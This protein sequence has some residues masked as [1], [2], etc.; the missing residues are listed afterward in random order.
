MTQ[1]HWPLRDI[2]SAAEHNQLYEPSSEIIH[3]SL[4]QREQS[5]FPDDL[6]HWMG[7]LNESQWQTQHR[8]LHLLQPW[9]LT[10]KEAPSSS[11]S[12]ARQRNI[13]PGIA[14]PFKI[15]PL[16]KVGTRAGI[17]WNM[18]KI[19]WL[20]Y[21]ER[22][23][24][25][26][27]RYEFTNVY[28]NTSMKV[29]LREYGPFHYNNFGQ[30][31]KKNSKEK[32]NWSVLMFQWNTRHGSNGYRKLCRNEAVIPSREGRWAGLRNVLFTRLWTQ[33]K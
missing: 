24:Y 5:Y 15:I 26:Y 14:H 13:I 20:G 11:R 16:L 18:A 28:R 3:F 9:S 32:N 25:N 4:P 7:W 27:V 12:G 8:L 6:P 22:P 31:K 29:D 17:A 30:F 23:E 1:D 19:V 10:R 2:T 33:W 21:A